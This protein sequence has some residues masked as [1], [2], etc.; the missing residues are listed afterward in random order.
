MRYLYDCDTWKWGILPK[1]PWFKA[2]FSLYIGIAI[3]WLQ[4]IFRHPYTFFDIQ[5]FNHPICW[6]YLLLTHSPTHESEDTAD[7]GH[8]VSYDQGRI[9][10]KCFWRKPMQCAQTLD[11]WTDPLTD[12]CILKVCNGYGFGSRFKGNLQE[13]G[14]PLIWFQQVTLLCWFSPKPIEMR[15]VWHQAVD[16]AQMGLELPPRSDHDSRSGS[17]HSKDFVPRRLEK[18]SFPQKGHVPP[19]ETDQ[20][21]F[22]SKNLRSRFVLLVPM[23]TISRNVIRRWFVWFVCSVWARVTWFTHTYPRKGTLP[24]LL[25][26]KSGRYLFGE[27]P[28][29]FGKTWINI[30]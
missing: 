8:S 18:V 17:L 28:P 13:P 3:W 11:L 25:C 23:A 27:Q 21:A 9:R 4:T 30:A 24:K 16:A 6:G 26:F 10:A 7:N 19:T 15:I 1:I 14:T 2:S 22:S 12:V 5:W 29:N 20:F